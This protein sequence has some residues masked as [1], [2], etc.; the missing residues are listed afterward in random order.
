LITKK[1]IGLFAIIAILTLSIATGNLNTTAATEPPKN[2]V[3][4]INSL[5]DLPNS[6]AYN[7]SR[8]FGHPTYEMNIPAHAGDTIDIIL[9]AYENNLKLVAG[10]EYDPKNYHE[11]DHCFKLTSKDTFR[12][13]NKE[14]SAY[15]YVVGS[16][17]CKSLEFF[18]DRAPKDRWDYHLTKVGVDYTLLE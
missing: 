12:M 6:T 1:Y 4:Y 2:H 18:Y 16:G 10:G 3:L 5:N 9:P 13:N 17:Y 15:H 7:V 11:E 8:Q 14:Y